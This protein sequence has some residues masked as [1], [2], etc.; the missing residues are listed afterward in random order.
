MFEGHRK[1]RRPQKEKE[2]PMVAN[3]GA[4]SVGLQGA[5]AIGDERVSSLLDFSW[6]TRHDSNVRGPK[7]EDLPPTERN[8]VDGESAVPKERRR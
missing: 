8:G 3:S 7:A 2:T 1:I 5:K 6:A 4:E